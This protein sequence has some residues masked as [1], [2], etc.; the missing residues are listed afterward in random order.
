VICAGVAGVLLTIIGASSAFAQAATAYSQVHWTLNTGVVTRRSV[1]SD[2]QL[3]PSYLIYRGEWAPDVDYI[4]GDVVKVNGLY[5]QGIGRTIVPGYFP[6]VP[7]TG[8]PE[9]S[10][11]DWHVVNPHAYPIL[12]FP[13]AAGANVLLSTDVFTF[14]R[15]GRLTITDARITPDTVVQ[16]EYVGGSLLPGLAV[17]IAAG[18]FTAVGLPGKKF[19]Y[20][21]IN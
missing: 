7:K 20:V 21:L 12:N 4:D 14:P 17:D 6:A 15:N 18:R 9:G 1:A 2:S 10:S 16:V 11:S 19:R 13:A 5:Y 8:T 3:C